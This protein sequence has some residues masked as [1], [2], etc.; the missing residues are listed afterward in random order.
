MTFLGGHRPWQTVV[1]DAPENLSI[2]TLRPFE[3]GYVTGSTIVLSGWRMQ[4]DGTNRL[5]K[6]FLAVLLVGLVQN[7]Q[8]RGYCVKESAWLHEEKSEGCFGM[9][10]VKLGR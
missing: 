3:A 8:R 7:S 6:A 5:W 4:V 9:F 10:G 2:K 1:E